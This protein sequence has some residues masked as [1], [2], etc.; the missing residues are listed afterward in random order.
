MATMRLKPSLH[1]VATKIA[2]EVG[3]SVSTATKWLKGG[4][5]SGVAD[6][7]LSLCLDGLGLSDW[8]PSARVPDTER[9]PAPASEA[10]AA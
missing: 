8:H 1:Q 2:A 6:R 10:P 5:V 9:Q 4:A 3:C 7:A